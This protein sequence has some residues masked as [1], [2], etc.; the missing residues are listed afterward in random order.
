MSNDFYIISTNATIKNTSKFL[1]YDFYEKELSFQVSC[2]YGPG[3]YDS[4][5]EEKGNDYPIAYVRWTEQRNFQA[6][7]ELIRDKKIITESLITHKFEFSQTK[8]IYD[9]IDRGEGSLGVVLEF[10]DRNFDLKTTIVVTES[11]ETE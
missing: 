10:P 9:I 1:D 8:K 7:L 11:V 5:Y 2:S 4:D 6:I 3:R